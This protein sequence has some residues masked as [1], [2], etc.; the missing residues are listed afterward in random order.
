MRVWFGVLV[1]LPESDVA[2]DV[3][4]PELEL[5]TLDGDWRDDDAEIAEVFDVAADAAGLDEEGA[6]SVVGPKSDIMVGED[7]KRLALCT[8]EEVGE[9]VIPDPAEEPALENCCGDVVLG[10]VEVEIELEICCR[11]V[12]PTEFEKV[13]PDTACTEEMLS[14]GCE[15]DTGV[16]TL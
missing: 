11:D 10:D 14:C 15:D 8:P 5:T 1:E 12:V 13:E 4:A 6:V 3:R 9:D 16:E 7:G 2:P